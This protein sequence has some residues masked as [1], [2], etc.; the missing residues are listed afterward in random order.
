MQ[1]NDD[2]MSDVDSNIDKFS[3]DEDSDSDY[4]LIMILMIIQVMK[5][6]SHSLGK[7][8]PSKTDQVLIKRPNT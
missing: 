7:W 4:D 8:S 6:H 3:V 5:K 2:S 1:D